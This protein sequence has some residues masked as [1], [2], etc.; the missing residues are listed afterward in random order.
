MSQFL[1][2]ANVAVTQVYTQSVLEDPA[3]PAGELVVDTFMPPAP[4]RSWL[5]RRPPQGR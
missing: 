2:H 3:D 4:K 5:P 1:G